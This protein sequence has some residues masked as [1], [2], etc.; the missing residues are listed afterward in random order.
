[1][2]VWLLVAALD[3]LVHSAP[4][5]QPVCVESS[6]GGIVIACVVV[7]A[8][9]VIAGVVGAGGAL[10]FIHHQPSRS[11][12]LGHE[13]VMISTPLPCVVYTTGTCFECIC[14]VGWTS[15]RIGMQGASAR[16]QNTDCGHIQMF[17][18]PYLAQWSVGL[19]GM[20]PWA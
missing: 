7:V 9:V 14:V 8:G 17:T 10:P 6:V 12:Y 20:L 15:C 1:M 13:F 11:T 18:T 19:H 5:P 16:Q 2:G 4:P 3:C